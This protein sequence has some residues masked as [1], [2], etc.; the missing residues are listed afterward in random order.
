MRDDSANNTSEITGREGN[1]ELSS[2]AIGFFGFGEDVGV[3]ELDDL[4]KEEELGHSIRDLQGRSR[5]FAN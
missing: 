2:L 1:T 4:L 5:Q 3:E